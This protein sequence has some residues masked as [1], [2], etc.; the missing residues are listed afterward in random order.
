MDITKIIEDL[1]REIKK[2]DTDNLIDLSTINKEFDEKYK[3]LYENQKEKFGEDYVKKHIDDIQNLTFNALYYPKK[4]QLRDNFQVYSYLNYGI[5]TKS[6]GL[7]ANSAKELFLNDENEALSKYP[8]EK[9]KF[10]AEGNIFRIV[11]DFN[12][13]TQTKL[14]KVEEKHDKY[15]IGVLF[16]KNT[17]FINS[18]FVM[19]KI[20][21]NN[22]KLENFKISKIGIGNKIWTDEDDVMHCSLFKVYNTIETKEEVIINSFNYIPDKFTA[23]PK[24][25]KDI[26]TEKRSFLMQGLVFIKGHLLNIGEGKKSLIFT[27]TNGISEAVNELRVYIPKQEIDFA[28]GTE[29]IVLGNL[30]MGE[31]AELIFNGVSMFA[32]TSTKVP[33][34]FHIEEDKDLNIPQEDIQKPK[35]IIDNLCADSSKEQA[36]I[37]R[38]KEEERKTGNMLV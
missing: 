24:N 11:K 23:E 21:E 1:K 27:L 34:T 28:V 22:N 3:Y 33:K 25:A 2:I 37:D 6:S 17:N 15:S 35:S 9:F 12:N 31:N 13:P 16:D 20:Y 29:L 8:P 19:L 32:Q 4:E 5:I 14:L 18:K 10:D 38:E 7:Y 36:D 26:L 30:F